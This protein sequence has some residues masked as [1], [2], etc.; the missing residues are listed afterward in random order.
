MQRLFNCNRSKVLLLDVDG[1]ILQHRRILHQVSRNIVNYCKRELYVSEKTAITINQ[2]LY[3]EYGHSYRGL[4]KVYD[5]RRSLHHFNTTVYDEELVIS[6]IETDKDINQHIHY[7]N[8][9]DIV[10]RCNIKN[11]PV[12]LFTNAPLSWCK[13]VL[14]TSGLDT[15]IPES[16]IISC[17]HDAMLLHDDDG[18]KPVAAVYETIKTFITNEHH[19]EDP[20]YIFVEDSFKNLV[21]IIGDKSWCPVFFNSD[22]KGLPLS[23]IPTISNIKEGKFLINQLIHE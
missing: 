18:F 21:P 8:L 23:Y 5:L 1:V 19:L 3:T 22:V 6:V 20:L 10:L 16:Q 17:E 9:K 7:M 4:R 14:S 12:Y 11:V 15:L 2:L 13:S